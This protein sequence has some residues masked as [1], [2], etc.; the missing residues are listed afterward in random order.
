MGILT[1]KKIYR[2]QNWSNKTCEK[3]PL[4]LSFKWDLFFCRE[5]AFMW[6]FLTR[7]WQCVFKCYLHLSPGF[8]FLQNIT[9]TAMRM[10]KA[11][12]QAAMTA[13]MMMSFAL[14]PSFKRPIPEKNQWNS[15]FYVRNEKYFFSTLNICLARDSSSNGIVHKATVQSKVV[16]KSLDPNCA[17][18]TLDTEV[19]QS[20]ISFTPTKSDRIWVVYIKIQ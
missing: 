13:M 8:C 18:D 20:F 7:V 1:T 5:I 14:S 12:T 2:I 6:I 15:N 11:T 10:I 16:F 9:M 4:W 17:D 19:D 3:C